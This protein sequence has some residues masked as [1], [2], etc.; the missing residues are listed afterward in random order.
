MYSTNKNDPEPKTLMIWVNGELVEVYNEKG[1][2][3]IGVETN[4][5]YV[6][7]TETGHYHAEGEK[8]KPV[9]QKTSLK[10]TIIG[11][12][13]RKQERQ[14]KT[15][16]IRPF[17]VDYGIDP[18]DPLAGDIHE[19]ATDNEGNAYSYQKP[20]EQKFIAPLL[21]QKPIKEISL[22]PSEQAR[23]M[24]HKRKTFRAGGAN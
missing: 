13:L 8:P 23:N 14:S 5:K 10:K 22:S 21:V 11:L 9:V 19:I 15:V 4:I 12:I 7:D 6:R 20:E 3:N 16:G 18:T 2:R 1:R 17:S 24:A